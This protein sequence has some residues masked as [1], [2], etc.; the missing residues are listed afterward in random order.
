MIPNIGPLEILIVVAILLIIF[1]PRKLPQ[2][3]R[4]AG[5]SLR[6]FRRSVDLEPGSDRKEAARKEANRGEAARGEA[7]PSAAATNGSGGRSQ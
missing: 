5:Q 7:T 3:G 1:G 2:L 6:E 4:S